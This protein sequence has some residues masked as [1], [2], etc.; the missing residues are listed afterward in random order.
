[1]YCSEILPSKG[2][3]IATMC[4]WL[5]GTILVFAV[6][7]LNLSVLFIFY[8]AICISG[9]LFIIT[10]LEE[11]KDKSKAEIAMLFNPKKISTVSD[12]ENEQS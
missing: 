10:F 4:N 9:V 3:S 1:M 5:A 8:T 7:Y 12:D 6:P 2:I 11:T